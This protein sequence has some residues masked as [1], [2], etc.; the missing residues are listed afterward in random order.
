M[1]AGRGTPPDDGCEIRVENMWIIHHPAPEQSSL[2]K[3][4]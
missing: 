4:F 1:P 2:Q 3:K